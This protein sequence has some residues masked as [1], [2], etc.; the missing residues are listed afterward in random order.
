MY[1]EFIPES[2]GAAAY[3]LQALKHC[4]WQYI[5]WQYIWW[6]YIWWQYIWWQYIWWQYIW[7]QY[8]C[9]WP[10]SNLTK[11]SG[12]PTN[13]SFSLVPKPRPDLPLVSALE[14]AA[15]PPAPA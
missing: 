14:A 12:R 5:W 15:A 11:L 2:G 3:M 4:W 1:W 8:I 10:L 6:Q 7:W 13:S 9:H